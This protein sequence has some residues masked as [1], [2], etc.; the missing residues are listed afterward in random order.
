MMHRGLPVNLTSVVWLIL[1]ATLLAGCSSDPA[2]RYRDVQIGGQTFRLEVADTDAARFRGL[3]G[4]ASIPADGGMIF[5]F[6]DER[7]RAFVMRDCLVPIDILFLG[8][9]GEVSA[10]Y[11]MEVEPPGTP[12]TQLKQYRSHGRSAVVIELAGGT[13]DR[14]DFGVGDRLDLPQRQMKR[15]AR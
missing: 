10:A 6:P 14:L 2:V 9:T 4:R 11:T 3:S 7:E 13:L 8:P 15:D 5:I 12:D 1:S